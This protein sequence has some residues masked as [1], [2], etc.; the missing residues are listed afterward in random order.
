MKSNVSDQMEFMHNVYADACM[1]CIADVSDLRDL[2]TIR[3]RVEHE[4]IS[5]LTITLPQFCRDFERSLAEGIIDSTYFRSFRKYG[6]IPAFLQGMIS[7][8]FDWETGRIY[9][10]TTE[11]GKSKM[12]SSDFV[13]SVEC[14]RQICLVFK[15]LEIDCTQTR[16]QSSLDQF[17]A[18]EQSLRLFSLP[19]ADYAKF[20]SVS[21]V[22][23]DNMVRTLV[24][25]EAV[26]HHGPGATAD[27]LAG[28]SKYV[29]RRW[30]ERLEPYFP[31]VGSGYPLGL[32]E[33]SEE[34]KVV[35][36]VPP[37]QEQPVRVVTVPKT[38]KSPRI[39]AIEPCCVQYAQQGLR[40]LL[41]EA[42]EGA[43]LSR[44]HVNFRD[45]S[46][47]Q[48]LAVMSSI[49][50]QL[51]TI[52]LSDASDRVPHDL[53]MEMFRANPDFQDAVDACRSTRAQLPDGTI[54]SLRKFASM[55][56]ALCFPVEAMYFY[57]ICVMALLEAQNLPVTF[58]NCFSV[59]RNVHVYG[60]D[61]IV[62]ATYA[63]AV[64]AHLRKYNCKVNSNKTFV[65]GRFRESCGIDAF[66]GEPVTPVYLRKMHPKNRQQADNLVSWV[67]TANLFYKRGYWRTS[68]FMFKELER[69][70]GPLPYV[71]E[72]SPALGRNSYL[73][74]RSAERW[75][76]NLQRLEIKA[77]VPS[78]VYRTDG[79]DGYGAL[80]KSF[81]KLEDLVDPLVI[82]D[83]NHLEH[84]ALHGAVTLKRR[85]VPSLI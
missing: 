17:T 26:P 66:H 65:T 45:Q 47:N 54:L 74:Y 82:R 39:I 3:S 33:D 24:L 57:T 19:E 46:V 50:G 67:A 76:N 42:V 52:D 30:H 62:P 77:W 9:D 1:K 14:V 53:A 13:V 83:A 25:A 6:S 68:Q 5:F 70:L 78:P 22:L 7:Q 29:W 2:E 61:I 48:Q 34:L 8:V 72:T 31:L 60:D 43:W 44:G 55:G 37:E 51:A 64:L 27:K 36:L 32:P 11:L 28:N 15:K 58:R 56:S 81:Q 63:Y 18:T 35:S 75:N 10:E 12:V 49:S 21:A 23:W 69:I 73:G 79:L 41:Y 71:S 84:S 40:S 20:I 38:L 16:I 85:W 4:G 80:M 59:S